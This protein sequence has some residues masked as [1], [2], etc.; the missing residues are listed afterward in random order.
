MSDKQESIQG[1]KAKMNALKR[2]ITR[3]L[4]KSE[5]ACRQFA[6]E[7]EETAT[8]LVMDSLAVEIVEEGN[9]V[10]KRNQKYGG[11]SSNV[12]QPYS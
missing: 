7:N 5:K 6:D 12:N 8:T 3:A 11:N 9:I 4:K 10:R 1:L 2:R